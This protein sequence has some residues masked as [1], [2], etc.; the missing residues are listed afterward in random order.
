MGKAK[1]IQIAG[2]HYKDFPIQ[3]IEFIVENKLDWFQGNIVKYTC[4]HAMKNG[5][6]DLEKVIHYAQ[7]AIEHYYAENKD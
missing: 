7:L 3:P 4:R 1:E 6:E 5:K 2:R